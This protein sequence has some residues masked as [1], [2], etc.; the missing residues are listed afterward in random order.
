MA[1][2][3]PD[4]GMRCHCGGDIDDIVFD[5][6]KYSKGCCCCE[7]KYLPDDDDDNHCDGDQDCYRCGGSGE[8]PT[9]DFESYLGKMVKPCPHCYGGLD[10][11]DLS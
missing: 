1:H 10:I 7:S 8:V 6:N 3:C 2:E 11:K 9:R 4:C 5:D